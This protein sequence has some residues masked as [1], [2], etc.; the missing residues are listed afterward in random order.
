MK[1]IHTADWHLGA[2]FYRVKMTEEQSF[3]LDKLIK[4]IADE[5]PDFMV[6]SGDNIRQVGATI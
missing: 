1:F 6:V 4:L 5:R 3:V 2:S